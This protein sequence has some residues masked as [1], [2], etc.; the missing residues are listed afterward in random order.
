MPPIS[1][2]RGG[3]TVR[4]PMKRERDTL[5]EAWSVAKPWRRNDTV[6]Y[7]PLDRRVLTRRGIISLG[8]TCNLQCYFCYFRDRR[9]DANHPEHEF[10]SMEKAE[11]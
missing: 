7:V 3:V 8:Q 11:R 6:A 2:R 4:N 9:S 1:Q 5:E 10:M